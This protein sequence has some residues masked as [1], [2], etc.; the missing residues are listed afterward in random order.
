AAGGGPLA[1]GV[2]GGY[3]LH[4]AL[5]WRPDVDEIRRLIT[6][7]TRAIYVN[8]PSNPTG[9]VLTRDDILAIADLARSRNL[10]VISDEAYEDVVFDGQEHFSIASL[11]GM[12]DRTIPVYTF[13]KTY[14]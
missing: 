7:K 5:G 4:E 6:P 13:S 12:Y 10:W 2:P 1:R 11:P 8:S 14:A 9:G 3:R